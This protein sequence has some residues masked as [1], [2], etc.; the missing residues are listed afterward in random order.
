MDYHH[1]SNMTTGNVLISWGIAALAGLIA[2]LLLR[3]LGDWSLSAAGFGAGF[4]VVVL[5]VIFTII[6]GR[7]LTPLAVPEKKLT[8]RPVGPDAPIPTRRAAPTASTGYPP[9]AEAVPGRVEVSQGTSSVAVEDDAPARAADEGMARPVE[10]VDAGRSTEPRVTPVAGGVERTTPA[11]AQGGAAASAADPEEAGTKPVTLD[12]PRGGA[13][14]DLKQIRGVGPK[15]EETC[16]RMG[17]W[18]FDQIAAWTP[19]EVAWVDGNLE[20]FKGRVS[21]DEWVAQAQVLAAGGETEFS[22]RTPTDDDV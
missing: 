4:I 14:D 9:A 8:P 16:N 20:G 22:R 1:N 5:A 7:D 12:A 19:A 18:H 21:R 13:G 17:F 3:I 2:F 10:R 6:F 11:A 15:M